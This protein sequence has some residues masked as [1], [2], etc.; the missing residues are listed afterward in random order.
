MFTQIGLDNIWREAKAGV[1]SFLS[2]VEI[3]CDCDYERC[4]KIY[5]HC[6]KCHAY[7]SSVRALHPLDQPFS[8]W[9]RFAQWE[10]RVPGVQKKFVFPT[11]G[12]L[13]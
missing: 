11:F 13:L 5:V 12:G 8:A 3:V 6:E 4:L 7:F 2:D 10:P 9:V 1:Y